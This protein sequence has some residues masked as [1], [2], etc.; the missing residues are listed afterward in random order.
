[1]TLKGDPSAWRLQLARHV[2]AAYARNPRVATVLIAG[3]VSRGHADRDSDIELMIGWSEPPSDEE[4][5]EIVAPLA[6]DLN[7]LPF[8][9]A[10]Q[11]WQ[12][13]FFVG[14]SSA[15]EPSS[16]VLVEAVGQLTSVIDRRLADV[17]ERHDPD[18]DKQTSVHA[19]LHGVPLH[20]E[21]L[22]GSWRARAAAYPRGL[23]VAM[24]N[25]Y[26]QVDY[27]ADW[28]R[29]LARGNNLMLIHERFTQV[30]RQLLLV[31]QAI[32]GRYHYKFKWL[33]RAIAELEIAPADLAQRL[34]EVQTADVPAAAEALRVLVEEVYDLVE[35]HLPEVAVGRLREVFRWE[36]HPWD[37]PPPRLFPSLD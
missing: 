32:N 33:D 17:V 31:L 21:A 27:F 30:E 19:V 8:D 15:D 29:F 26:G 23:A 37:S 36:R 34:R 18:L 10:W 12:E 11:C 35:A 4:R 13:D 14:R 9:D 2:G 22:I 7:L 24:V 5:R 16:G 3:S 6:A 25:R 20:G 28:K 1:V